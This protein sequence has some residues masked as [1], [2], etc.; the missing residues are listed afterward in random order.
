MYQ[1]YNLVYGPL[2]EKIFKP[3]SFP[4]ILPLFER[5]EDNQYVE[6]KEDEFVIKYSQD[7]SWIK[8]DYF[9][10]MFEDKQ[11]IQSFDVLY[12]Y[13]CNDLIRA[14]RKGENLE[15]HYNFGNKP[16]AYK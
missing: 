7:N 11:E 4:K 15:N 5:K 8:N 13:V 9:A 3:I 12:G 1:N 16:V 2:A 10:S 14:Y 6:N